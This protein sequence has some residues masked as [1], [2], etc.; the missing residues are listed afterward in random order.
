MEKTSFD[1]GMLSC[2][3][4]VQ[5]EKPDIGVEA[6]YPMLTIYI[7]A[8]SMRVVI[9]QCL[10]YRCSPCSVLVVFWLAGTN[11]R[12]LTLYENQACLVQEI[13]GKAGAKSVW[14][15]VWYITK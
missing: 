3:A 10:H 14:D 11:I 8:N 1:N 2:Q 6:P 12:A 5:L 4:L 9:R 13:H 7:K 15:M